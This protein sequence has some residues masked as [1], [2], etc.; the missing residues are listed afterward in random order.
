L[1][2]YSQYGVHVALEVGAMETGNA[3]ETCG[4]FVIQSYKSS[5]K[6]IFPL[7]VDEL[8]TYGDSSRGPR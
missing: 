4:T 2:K 5:S 8:I 6:F 1:T 7:D 3:R